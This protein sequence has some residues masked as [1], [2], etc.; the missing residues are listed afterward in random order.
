FPGCVLASGLPQG[1][2][3]TPAVT[4]HSATGASAGAGAG[5]GEGSNAGALRGAGRIDLYSPLI[6]VGAVHAASAAQEPGGLSRL[7]TDDG[8]APAELLACIRQVGGLRA[9]L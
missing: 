9:W 1:M 2:A 6:N 4:A 7:D 3:M 8:L 5:G